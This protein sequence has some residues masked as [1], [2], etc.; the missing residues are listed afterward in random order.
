MFKNYKAIMYALVFIPALCGLTGCPSGG[1]KIGLP[2]P[3]LNLERL[4]GGTKDIAQLKGKVVLVNFWATWCAPCVEEMP[5]LEKL[6]RELEG[7]DFV[8]IAVSVDKKRSTIEKFASKHKLSFPILHD[9]GE[10]TARSWGTTGFPETFIV[11]KQG[12][13]AHKFIGPIDYEYIHDK[14]KELL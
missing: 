7:Q 11:D 9:P 6:H 12:N 3:A 2:A 5:D 14:V 8:L 13:V 4:G 10:K 1:A